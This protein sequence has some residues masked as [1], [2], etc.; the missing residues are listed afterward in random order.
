MLTR[1]APGRYA[2]ILPTEISLTALDQFAYG[3]TEAALRRKALD[4]SVSAADAVTD[5]AQG[6][7]EARART[8]RSA[9]D[10]IVDD[11]ETRRALHLSDYHPQCYFDLRAELDASLINLPPA[12]QACLRDA[13]RWATALR[14]QELC[15]L[16]SHRPDELQC[17]RSIRPCAS[18]ARASSACM[19]TRNASFAPRDSTD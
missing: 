12:D 7:A 19:R 3:G 8:Q 1:R 5:F 15:D 6:L 13:A 11:W 9:Y 18:Q 10:R 17:K 14:A 2:P 4:E 16:P